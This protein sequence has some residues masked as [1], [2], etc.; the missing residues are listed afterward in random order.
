MLVAVFLL[1]AALT[2][3][4]GNAATAAATLQRAE[5]EFLQGVQAREQPDQASQHFRAAFADYE[6]LRR[7]GANNTALY[8][9]QGNAA[10]L[11]G[12]VPQAILAFRRALRLAPGD[13]I[14][15]ESLEK[16]RDRVDYPKSEV[17]PAA[18]DWPS[19][20]PRPSDNQLLGLAVGIYSLGCIAFTRWLM[21]RQVSLVFL[22]AAALV[23]AGTLGFR[24]ASREGQIDQ[25]RQH[26]L[27]VVKDTCPLRTGNGISYPPQPAL[28]SVRRG[29]EGT[30]QFVRGDW[31]QVE[32]PGGAVG[33]LRRDQVLLDTP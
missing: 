1:S 16:A 21:I 29:M 27:L 24:W 10:F 4:P 8:R 9:N 13:G 33:W 20:L 17:R 6:T 31:L 30:L 3:D 14:L 23:L 11:A 22:A 5:R 2:A 28:S 7:Q 18:P 25:Q 32:F 15:Q 26:P 12:N 19:W